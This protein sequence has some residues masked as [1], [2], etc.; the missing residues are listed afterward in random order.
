MWAERLRTHRRH[1]QNA[2]SWRYDPVAGPL[3]QRKSSTREEVERVSTRTSFFNDFSLWEHL[4]AIAPGLL[5]IR[6][7]SLCHPGAC[8]EGNAMLCSRSCKH[9]SSIIKAKPAFPGTPNEAK[10]KHKRYLS[11]MNRHWH[12]KEFPRVAARGSSNWPARAC[13]M[14]RKW[15]RLH[16]ISV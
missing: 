10:K 5:Q 8:A 1:L 6:D 12:M 14:A 9:G 13:S 7:R 11:H 4:W 16:A 15:D 3:R 2:P